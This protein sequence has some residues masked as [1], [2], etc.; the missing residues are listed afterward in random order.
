MESF[1]YLRFLFNFLGSCSD[2]NGHSAIREETDRRRF[3]CAWQTPQAHWQGF[4][5]YTIM[6]S[7]GAPEGSNM[8][9]YR[10][11]D[12]VCSWTSIGSFVFLIAFRK[13]LYFFIFY[14][15]QIVC[16]WLIQTSKRLKSCVDEYAMQ[17][18]NG[19][20]VSKLF[21]RQVRKINTNIKSLNTH[22]YTFFLGK[23]WKYGTK[24]QHLCHCWESISLTLRSSQSINRDDKEDFTAEIYSQIQFTIF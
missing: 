9:H 17:A 2:S 4:Q 21:I 14:F 18:D 3:R 22:F 11:H 24:Y 23:I 6:F 20:I 8:G 1:Y 5:R 12:G 19:E 10:V 16:N 7:W 15:F 13:S